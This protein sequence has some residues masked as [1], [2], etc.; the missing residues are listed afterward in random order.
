MP[1]PGDSVVL[2][3]WALAGGTSSPTDSYTYQWFKDGQALP[4]ATGA[5]LP[6]PQV[7]LAD[8]GSYRARITGRGPMGGGRI[9]LA[10]SVMFTAP[11]E[12]EPADQVRVVTRTADTGAGTLREALEAVA[13][14]PVA[15]DVVTGIRFELPPL[16]APVIWLHSPLPPITRNVRILGPPGG[17]LEVD[18]AGAHR[19]FFVDG[20]EVILDNF[21]VVH[22]LAKGGNA[23]GG[24]G[25]AAGM[26]GGLFL[27]KGAVTLRRMTF[28]GNGAV[29]GAS[30][31]GSDGENGGGG[32]FGGDSP[33]QGGAGG[34][35][36]FLKGR[37]GA[38]Y[39]DG[40]T[41]TDAGGGPAVGGDG[42]GGGAARGGLAETPLALWADN[43]PGG[44]G[45]FGGG[46]GF[47][48]GPL[49]GGAMPAPSA[50]AEAVP[51]AWP[52]AP[53]CRGPPAARAASSAATG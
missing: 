22:G 11:F 27:N 52:G 8:A 9:A 16:E 32:G 36:G 14:Q 30:A 15:Q 43:L 24:G 35:G 2:D 51:G 38:G 41:T 44:T 3:A 17:L 12:L 19:P 50:A 10:H 6:F 47:S 49:G 53:S 7:A 1:H 37:G 48:V 28:Q 29:G 33:A 39:L 40:T 4:G 20:G 25:G 42:A 18:G 26:G 34:D 31:P 46:G 21:Q 13:S 45:T 23:T 5:T